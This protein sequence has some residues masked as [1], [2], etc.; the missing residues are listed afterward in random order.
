M[1]KSDSEIYERAAQ[2]IEEHGHVKGG[3]GAPG[4]GFCLMAALQEACREARRTGG[5]ISLANRLS[6]TART[7]WGHGA[8]PW[9]DQPERTAAEVVAFLREFA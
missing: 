5:Y 2:L 7:R 9:N 8:I 6:D 4:R 1:G 3:Y